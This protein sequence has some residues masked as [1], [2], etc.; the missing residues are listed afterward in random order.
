MIYNN[1]HYVR[2]SPITYHYTTALDLLFFFT[3]NKKWRVQ[4][5]QIVYKIEE[6]HNIQKRKKRIEEIHY[7]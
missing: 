6:I 1:G 4:N 7:M 5:R 3:F 2:V